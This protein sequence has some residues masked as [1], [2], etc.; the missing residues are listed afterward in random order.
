MH[1]HVIDSVDY[2]EY[3]S[4]HRF[5]IE[6]STDVFALVYHRRVLDTYRIISALVE[7]SII[8]QQ[9]EKSSTFIN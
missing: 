9:F 1:V 6:Q 7:A 3:L 8:V 2:I 4:H 5:G